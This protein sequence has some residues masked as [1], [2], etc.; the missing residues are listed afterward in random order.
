VAP[1]LGSVALPDNVTSEAAVSNAWP[2][3]VT[4][5][6]GLVVSQVKVMNLSGPT[7]PAL[8]T[9]CECASYTL[10]LCKFA[11][12]LNAQPDGSVPAGFDHCAVAGVKVLPPG[13]PQAPPDPLIVTLTPITTKLS[14]EVPV[15]WLSVFKSEPAIGD[16]TVAVGAVVS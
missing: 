11:R 14:T 13:F 12:P 2:G 6:V 1:A 4:W 10:P 7:L 5:D 9:A 15:I 8:S 3:I 16:V